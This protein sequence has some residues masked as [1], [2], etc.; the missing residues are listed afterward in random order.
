MIKIEAIFLFFASV[1][2]EGLFPES[3]LFKHSQPLN[4]FQQAYFGLDENLQPKN[5]LSKNNPSK[6]RSTLNL[7]KSDSFDPSFSKKYESADWDIKST[8]NFL[9]ANANSESQGQCAKYIR[10][11]LAKGGIVIQGVRSAKNLGNSLVASG[12]REIPNNSE[13]IA[14]DIAVIQPYPSGID[15]HSAMFDGSQWISDFKQQ[16]LYPG[17]SYRVSQ[18]P[19]VFYRLEGIE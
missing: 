3:L 11:A 19:Y 15:G 16:E 5:D 9:R 12:F 13:P 8:L 6:N 17:P 7:N 18:P 10:L 1:V 14:G 2:S 4:Q